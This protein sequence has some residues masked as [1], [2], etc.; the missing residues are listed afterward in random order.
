MFLNKNQYK[1]I[2]KISV[3]LHTVSTKIINRIQLPSL[4][5]AQFDEA[6]IQEG[7]NAQQEHNNSQGNG[8]EEIPPSFLLAQN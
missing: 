4:S 3:Q 6:L 5:T 1:Q 2:N 7:Y 8:F